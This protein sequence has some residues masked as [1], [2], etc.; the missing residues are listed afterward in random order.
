MKPL[1]PPRAYVSDDTLRSE[2]DAFFPG[3]WV[4]VGSTRQL[5]ND[6]DFLTFSVGLRNVVVQNFAGELRAFTNVCS[7]RFNRIQ[8]EDCGNRTLMC[9]YHGWGYDAEGVPNRIPSRPRFEGIRA[10]DHSLERWRLETCGSLI[11]ICLQADAP[12]LR[13]RLGECY[14]I[15]AETTTAF[16]DLID[17]NVMMV[18]CNWKL[19]VEN[20]LEG[21]HVPWVH[22]TTIMR[23]GSDE[24]DFAFQ[25]PNHSSVFTKINA[26]A[27]QKMARFESLFESRPYKID[28]YRHQ[29]IFPT[30]TL[31][32]TKGMSFALQLFEPVTTAITKFTSLVFGTKLEAPPPSAEVVLPMF[33]K[34]VVDLNRAIFDEDRI[35][36]EQLQLG[37][38]DAVGTGVLSDEELRVAA[39]HRAY[40]DTMHELAMHGRTAP[41]NA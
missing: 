20:T 37:V 34:S 7:H 33:H 22:P 29:L 26:A 4:C 5:P 18:G 30:C 1:I 6:D 32:T 8:T 10:C 14:D 21:Y 16:G 24:S 41:A 3:Q 35:V 39:F 40:L 2:C 25:A 9:R 11:F 38:R 12:P 19:F 27:N 17:R 23:I 15:V 36:C 13:E 31:A 28:G